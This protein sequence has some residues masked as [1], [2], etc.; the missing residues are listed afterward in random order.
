MDQGRLIESLLNMSVFYVNNYA[1]VCATINIL[2]DRL[3]E[4]LHFSLTTWPQVEKN[5][6]FF[7]TFCSNDWIALYTTI[8]VAV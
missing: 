3:H 6:M 8:I 2:L 5:S 7:S 4:S 1:V